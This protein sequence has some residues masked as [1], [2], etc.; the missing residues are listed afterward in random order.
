MGG[1]AEIDTNALQLKTESH[2]CIEDHVPGTRAQPHSLSSMLLRSTQ[3]GT[4]HQTALSINSA[5][6]F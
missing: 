4:A 5:G 3:E 2:F 1:G 6:Y